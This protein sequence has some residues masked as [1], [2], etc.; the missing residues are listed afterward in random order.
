VRVRIPS[1]C[2]LFIGMTKLGDLIAKRKLNEGVNF[3][4]LTDDIMPGSE[5]GKAYIT[6]I[7]S[8]SYLIDEVSSFNDSFGYALQKQGITQKVNTATYTQQLAEIMKLLEG[9]H[10][11]VKFMSDVERRDL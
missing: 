8:L 10:Q 3:D 1:Y 4:H 9:L 11:P 5:I 6:A 7:R 2:P